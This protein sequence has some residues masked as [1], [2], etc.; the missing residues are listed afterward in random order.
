MIAAVLCTVAVAASY[1]N[2]SVGLVVLVVPTVW[3]AVP[4]LAALRATKWGHVPELSPQANILF[5][6][7]EMVRTGAPS[8]AVELLVVD[9]DNRIVTRPRTH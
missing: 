4:S 6:S 1:F 8:N 2:L 5:L 7:S 9:Q 3:V